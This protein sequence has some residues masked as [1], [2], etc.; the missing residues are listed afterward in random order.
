MLQIFLGVTG[1]AYG[2]M[3]RW[4]WF[5]VAFVLFILP[6]CLC[7]YTLITGVSNAFKEDPGSMTGLVLVMYLFKC[8]LF[9][10]TIVIWI[11]GIV[12]ISNKDLDDGNG[13]KLCQP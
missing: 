8:V 6:C 10:A 4:D 2:Y 1:A 5:S 12:M 3:D 13:M 11:W 9:V 7:C